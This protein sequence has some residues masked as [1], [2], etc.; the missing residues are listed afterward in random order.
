[1]EIEVV[2][3]K[4]TDLYL[5]IKDFL[6]NQ[7][8]LVKGEINGVDI[9]AMK[10]EATIA[11]ELKV[12]ITMKLVYQAIDRQ[13]IADEVY[14]AIPKTAIKSHRN[15]LKNF[16][17]LLKRLAIGLLV[18]SGNTVEVVLTPKDYDLDISKKRN[19]RRKEKMISSLV[20]L[21]SDQNKGG[22]KGKRMTIY[23]QNVIKIAKLL[24]ENPGMSP[25]AIKDITKIENVSSILQKNYYQWF[26][27]KTRGSY[28]LNETGIAYLRENE[29]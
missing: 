2:G 28:H 4:E 14:I 24:M 9:Y 21:T 12:N 19:L 11:I 20:N 15:N 7:G 26:E 27:R 6:V 10:E 29:N 23:K 13:R 22:S 5:P 18:V 3:M 25:K 17:L 16:L 8:Y 1:M